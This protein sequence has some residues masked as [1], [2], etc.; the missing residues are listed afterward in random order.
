MAINIDTYRSAIPNGSFDVPDNRLERIEHLTWK[1]CE[2]WIKF[3]LVNL[4][5][6][7]E[8][9]IFARVRSIDPAF[10]G[11]LRYDSADYSIVK[12]CKF[13]YYFFRHH[14]MLLWKGREMRDLV[15]E[16]RV[17][18]WKN[19]Q[20][21]LEHIFF[22]NEVEVE[23]IEEKNS[24]QIITESLLAKLEIEDSAPYIKAL[25]RIFPEGIQSIQIEEDAFTIHLPN[26][27]L[28]NADPSKL[29]PGL[30]TP[31]RKVVDLP[32]LIAVYR[33]SLTVDFDGIIYHAPQEIRGKIEEGKI[34]FNDQQ[35][36][37]IVPT[38]VITLYLDVRAVNIEGITY[39]PYNNTWGFGMVFNALLARFNENKNTIPPDHDQYGYLKNIHDA[40]LGVSK[41]D[42]LL[43]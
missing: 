20:P 35:V 43:T 12:V 5:E 25:E 17:L 18:Q 38:N 24:M 23:E 27:I 6:K 7:D 42:A 15:V 31:L 11:E 36:Y 41:R 1:N 8:T 2:V 21:T 29:D 13:V 33:E 10:L 26:H 16:A 22:P 39:R 34:V 9:K 4:L 3:L 30:Q 37:M 14:F 28:R 32:R 40:F 19:R